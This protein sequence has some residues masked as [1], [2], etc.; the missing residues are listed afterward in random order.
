[1]VAFI[2][3]LRLCPKRVVLPQFSHLA[4]PDRPFVLEFHGHMDRRK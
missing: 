4:I 1:L 2:E 3:K